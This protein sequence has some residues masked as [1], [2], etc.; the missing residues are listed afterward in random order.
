MNRKDLA[1]LALG[2]AMA[3]RRTERVYEHR[4]IHEHRAPTDESVALLKEFEEKAR[5]KM[6]AAVPLP[7]N[8]FDGV[9]FVEL[10]G[11]SMDYVL[12]VRAS[13]NGQKI[14][15]SVREYARGRESIE[16]ALPKLRDELAKEIAT[17]ILVDSLEKTV[18]PHFPR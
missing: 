12:S 9:A 18:L 4:D 5:E 1:L 2:G 11:M 16:K 10:D 6:L 3:G 7:P 15:A 17:K 8:V 14:E 13:I